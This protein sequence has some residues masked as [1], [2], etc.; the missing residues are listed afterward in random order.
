MR[1]AMGRKVHR[2]VFLRHELFYHRNATLLEWLRSRLW[3]VLLYREPPQTG[4]Y[5]ADLRAA[6]F[7]Q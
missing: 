4:S 2:V 1:H 7:I 5:D 3:S 6:Y